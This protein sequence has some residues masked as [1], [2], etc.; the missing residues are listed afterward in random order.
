MSY[1]TRHRTAANLLMM[2][3]V[4]AGIAAGLRIR[5]QFFPDIVIETVNVDV[6]WSGAG[7]E[8]VDSG[9][10]AVLL[11]AL[12]TVDGVT[13]TSSVAR[14]GRASI[15]L[16]FEPGWDMARAAEAV[17]AAVETAGT[18][19]E[20]TEDPEI[21]RGAWRDRVTDVVISGPVPVER[22]A[23]IA[24]SFA[25]RLFQAGIPRVTIQ[26]VAAPSLSV[27]VAE[28]DLIRHDVTLR[29][30]ADAITG[31]AAIRPAG[32]L[33]DGGARVR[34][35]T[36]S[37][38]AEAVA[39]V[40]V[41]AETDGSNLTVGDV[42]TIRVEGSGEGRTYFKGDDPAVTVR[43]DR[44]EQGDAI[45][46][47]A[48]VAETAAALQATLTDDIRIELIR[49][50]AEQITDRLDLLLRNGGLGLSLVVGLL[51]LFL[52]ARTAFWVA[53]GIPVAMATTIAVMY[54]AGLTINMISLFALIICLGVVVD[55]AIVV[56]EHADHRNRRLGEPPVVA[57]ETAARRMALPVLSSSLTTIIAFFGLVA[58]GGH[59][60]SLIA[61]IPFTVIAVLA[62]SLVECFLV[63]PNHMAHALAAKT[64]EPW[65][66]APSRL[67]N[68]GFRWFRERL[69]RRF[70]W[71][72]I[73]LR[74]PALAGAVLL[75][76]LAV[77]LFL[78][79]DV[80]WRFFN[81]PERPSIS[82]NVAMLPGATRTDTLAMIRELQRAT[83]AVAARYEAEHGT[84]PV[85][86][87][88]GE[89]GG[90]TGRS[91]AGSD[92]KDPDQLGSIAI[93]LI[94][95]D[96]RPYSSFDFLA[97][98]QAEVVDHP[99]LETL[100]F[101]GW[102]SG[103]GGD[104]LSVR[105]AG[106]DPRTL[107]AAAEA[108]KSALSAY[109]EVSALEDSLAYDKDELVLALTPQ[110]HALGFTIS[111][112]AS[113]LRNRLNGIEA[114]EFPVGTRTS[115]I[116]VRV[117]EAEVTAG[118]LH[119]ARLRSPAGDFVPLSEIV[120][121]APQPG[122]A[123]V[124][125]DNGLR[126]VTVSGDLDSDDADRAAAITNTLKTTILP[127]IAARHG[128]TASLGGLAEQERDF[129]SDALNGL[130][131]CLVG[132]YLVLAWIF[133]S[134]TRPLAVMAVI[135]FGL[136]GAIFGHWVW[137][138][139]LSLFSV[140]GLIGMTGI[141]IN[142]S[143]VLIDAIDE[144]AQSRAMLPAVVDAVAD[145]LR[146][147]L[148]TTLTTVLGLAPL[149]YE[150]SSQ[151]LFLKPT[152]IT[153][154]YGLGFGL[155][156]VL[157]TVPALVAIQQDV[158]GAVRSARRAL[159]LRVHR[160]HHALGRARPLLAATAV[161]SAAVVAATA[162]NWAAGGVNLAPV[163]ALGEVLHIGGGGLA[164]AGMLIGLALVGVVAI[165]AAALILPRRTRA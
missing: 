31:A 82:G 146:A 159:G 153:L 22:L 20:G 111:G 115:T 96:R 25:A 17:K 122:F 53:I 156:L 64:R 154:A 124:R 121:V 162:G 138:V 92:T 117:P 89:I 157:V 134:W 45:K 46:M 112:V 132:I 15:E 30:I 118:Y 94:D 86:F 97:D 93:E 140:V 147:V 28:A 13:E 65:Y 74:Y 113:E 119:E 103:P 128:V 38:S 163:V 58:I 131:L 7:P 95:P 29:D 135:P 56:G 19:P 42:A 24:D 70:V 40:V 151:A 60:G 52:S 149:L 125:R 33:A 85:S 1:F 4:V 127:D 105:L 80:Q 150:T 37:R 99:L 34:A 139:P 104:A 23:E 88:L 101:R 47:Q 44:N 133:A 66:D 12:Q 108:L 129:L 9:V 143:I 136:T 84:N 116:T 148:L 123:S 27:E 69:F 14:E 48:T 39:R 142:D 126:V 81:A 5:A 109:P 91:I 141:V 110:G 73:R 16:E 50:R 87:A 75:L 2:L 114:A 90:N 26:G 79:G 62:A 21:T 43:V 158:A 59:F 8:D 10:V 57:A 152:V 3:M 71:L 107:K 6:A 100:S 55:D 76:A 67:F 35:G 98:L 77:S 68:R 145:R 32:Q 63:L 165:V 51:F 137:D 61:D 161:A 155:V 72:V 120:R 106:A 36:E 11:P 102:R 83:G 164:I 18:L 78:R 130:V 41:R 54:M 49:T 160:P 144:K